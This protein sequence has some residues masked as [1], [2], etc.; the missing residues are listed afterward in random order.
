MM[1][2]PKL[3]WVLVIL[4]LIYEFVSILQ[5]GFKY[6]DLSQLIVNIALGFAFFVL[7][8][9]YWYFR[10]NDKNIVD[11]HKD[12]QSVTK[13]LDDLENKLIKLKNKNWKE[14]NKW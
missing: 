7:A 14:V 13:K 1:G 5:F 3:S 9:I 2:V 4:G 8:Y 11:I 6:Y 12:F 10:F